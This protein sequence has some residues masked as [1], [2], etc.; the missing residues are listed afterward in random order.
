MRTKQLCVSALCLALGACGG[1]DVASVEDFSRENDIRVTYNGDVALLGSYNE[2]FDKSGDTACVAYEDGEMRARV[3]EPTRNLTIELVQQ[4]EELA[5]K[6]GVDLNVK[7]RYAAIGGNAAVN[8]LDEF[9]N[10]ENSVTFLLSASADYMVR[11][12]AGNEHS[13]VLTDKGLDA[14]DGGAASFARKCGTHYV[15][16]VRY[17]ARFYLLINFKAQDHMAKTQMEASLGVDGSIAGSGDIKSRLEQTAKMAGVQVTVKTAS[18]GFWLGSAPSAELVKALETLKVDASLFGAATDLYFGM[19]KAVENEYCLDSGSGDCNGAP[20]PGYFARTR[21]DTSVTGVQLAS[22]HGLANAPVEHETFALLKDRVDVINRFVRNYS[23]IH[24]RMDSIYLDEVKPFL[25]APTHLK[26]L[27]NV[28]P[29]GKALDTP[30]QVYQVAK[31]L[32]ELIF[33]PTGGVMGWL[34]EDV[35]DRIVQ[36]LE[37]VNV[38]ITASCTAGDEPVAGVA[39]GKELDAD[40]TKAWNELYA[41]FATYHE[42]KRILPVQVAVG[43]WPVTYAKAQAHCDQLATNLNRELAKQGSSKT[44]VYRLATRDEVRFLAPSLSHANIK[45]TNADVLNATW[46]SPVGANPCGTDHPYFQS[47][48]TGTAA[49]GCAVNDWWDDDLI[50]LCV[51][52]S[53]PMPLMAPQ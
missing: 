35:H 40:E 52:S 44:V 45:W 37:K 1:D 20:S 16:G 34:R 13:L 18:S 46:Y 30:E 21:R 8:L 38:D 43:Q 11:D 7:A 24:L 6:L 48:P 2:L 31:E 4:K 19:T 26:A 23:E 17:G 42:Q 9:S 53:G 41:F 5:R 33:P 25:D 15:G 51:P 47:R 22:Y 32:D 12:V 27:Y 14:L 10:S 28:A 39:G 49:Y 3:S 29:P 36:C 50:T